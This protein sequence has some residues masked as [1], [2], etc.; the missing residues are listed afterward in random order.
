MSTYEDGEIIRLDPAT[1][2]IVQWNADDQC[3]YISGETPEEFGLHNIR[4]HE[5]ARLGL[6]NDG[7]VRS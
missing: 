2:Y 3:E 7:E 4:P 5:L 6:S 1:G